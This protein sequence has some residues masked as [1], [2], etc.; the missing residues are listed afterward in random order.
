MLIG[1]A[2]TVWDSYRTVG[3]TVG[4]W[5]AGGRLD[6]YINCWCGAID[7][8]WISNSFAGNFAGGRWAESGGGRVDEKLVINA[9]EH[10]VWVGC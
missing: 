2:W 6:G 9:G 3:R 7:T 10:D 5:G 8:S 1:K 4:R